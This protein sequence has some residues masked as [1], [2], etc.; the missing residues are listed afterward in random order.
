MLEFLHSSELIHNS[1]KPL[2]NI[3]FSYLIENVILL[4]DQINR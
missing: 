4:N 3:T 1:L 2:L